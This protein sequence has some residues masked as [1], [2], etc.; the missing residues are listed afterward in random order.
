MNKT[1]QV[2]KV[3]TDSPAV[4]KLLREI[5]SKLH[6]VLGDMDGVL[7]PENDPEEIIGWAIGQNAA[8]GLLLEELQGELTAVKR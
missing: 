1:E 8:A 6:A 4:T 7:D 2:D 5:Q 3:L